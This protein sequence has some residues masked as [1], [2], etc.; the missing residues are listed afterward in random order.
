M[1]LIQEKLR[2]IADLRHNSKAILFPDQTTVHNEKSNILTS[3]QRLQSVRDAIVGA[4]SRYNRTPGSVRLI[5]VG[6]V[7]SADTIRSVIQLG[8]E[9]IGESYVQEA[10]AKQ[11]LLGDLAVIWH[12]I[13][14][15]QSNK[16]R[17]IAASFDWVHSVDRVK[18]AQRLSAHRPAADAHLNICLQVNLEQETSKG[19]LSD[20]DID[21]VADAV[22]RLP[23]LR[24]RGLMAIPRPSENFD[25]QRENFRRVRVV[26]ERLQS[27]GHALDT[28]S[29]GMS[30]DM[31]AAIAE[32]TTMVRIGTALFGPRPKRPNTGV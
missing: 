22:G 6:K 1:H 2:D 28:L 31:E 27:R 3:E 18:I 10:V 16:T 26:F 12:Y 21:Q 14:H 32:G 4:E 9:D 5:G 7:H 19:G 11:K 29:M 8:L 13:G 17:E 20:K 15:I 25:E 30:S 23:H 24:L